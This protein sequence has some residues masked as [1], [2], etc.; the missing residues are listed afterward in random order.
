MSERLRL[1]PIDRLRETAPTA[2][3]VHIPFCKSRCFY[4]DFNTYVAP[5]AAMAAYVTAL[6]QELA[7]LGPLTDRP[8]ETVFIGG[9]TPTQLPVDLLER[10]FAALHTN[11]RVQPNA[12]ITVE[13]NPGSVE[14]DKL[15]VLRQGGTN[16]ISFGAQA[17]SDRLLMTIGRIHDREAVEASVRLAQSAGFVR[18]NLDLMFGLPEQ[19]I[20][21]VHS[22]LEAA[23]TLD[24]EHISAYWLKVEPGTP[25]AEWQ[26]GGKLPLPGEDAE[27]D[28]YDLVCDTLEQNGY[29]HYEVSNFAKS[30]GASRHNLVYWHNEPYLAAGAGA[31]GY[32][33]G[34]RYENLRDLAAYAARIQSGERPVAETWH[35]EPKESMEDTMM[36]GLRLSEGVDAK[37]FEW[38]HGVTLDEVFGDVIEPLVRQGLLTRRG[39]RVCLTPR[40]WPIAN[41][42]FEKFIG[43]DHAN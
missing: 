27:A 41:V 30:G 17:F 28:M 42:V 2:L 9:G 23:V 22:S 10:V 14:E 4:C 16:R 25:F 5:R 1:S 12:E 6:E 21:D 34:L 19:T 8:L 33:H 39:D 26:A 40:A 37:R 7:I 29:S 24:V 32:V 38:R 18:I 13:A 20:D 31:H 35:V 11:F 3:Y 43:V 15:K 36:L